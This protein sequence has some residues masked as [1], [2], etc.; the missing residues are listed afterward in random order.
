MRANTSPISDTKAAD[1]HRTRNTSPATNAKATDTRMTTHRSTIEN[2]T[3]NTSGEVNTQ[4]TTSS[5]TIANLAAN[6]LPPIAEMQRAYQG[7]NASYDGVFFLA[8]NTTGVFCRP[9]CP[10]RKPLP[11]NVRYFASV[12]EALFAGYRP[13]KRCH[14][15]EMPGRPPGWARRLLAAIDRDPSARL[16]D[17]DLR[18]FGVHPA[19]A[20]R[21]FLSHVPPGSATIRHTPAGRERMNEPRRGRKCPG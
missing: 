12:R 2:T 11:K 15:L 3:P 14:P 13:C 10:A 17:A 5:H 4:M 7:S 21:F 6:T 18:S 19:R 16:T 20:R 9:S 8:V 1:T